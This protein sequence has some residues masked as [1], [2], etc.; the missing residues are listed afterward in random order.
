M[1]LYIQ[2]LHLIKIKN[3][4]EYK[5]FLF[6]AA[7]FLTACSSE[8][9]SAG[10]QVHSKGEYIYRRHNEHLAVHSVRLA[11][12]PVY[13]WEK[14]K[15]GKYP[16]ITKEFF[17]CKGSSLNP[18]NL[19][20]KDTELVRYYDCG[21][22]RRHSLPLRDQ[23]EFIYPVLIDLLNYLQNITGNQA[24]IT[25]GHCCPDHNL[26]L[27]PSSANQTSKHLLGAEVD[28]Y[29]R[30]FENRPHQV[31]E[32]IKNYYKDNPQYKGQR[33]F[34]EFAVYEKSDT[35]VSTPPVYNK[36]IFVKVFTKT[37]GRDFDNRHPYPYLSVQV[38]YDRDLDE[39]V[40]YSWEKAFHNL[41]RH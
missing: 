9:T 10:L 32:L 22:S 35:G 24:V 18:V 20:Q 25:C 13:P 23:Q 3:R 29:I 34:E 27:N 8:D 5:Y 7:V 30:G 19:V 33:A 40:V 12:P 39:K 41:H 31:V 26:Y 16:K 1:T 36:E 28:F 2:K 21:G 6:L 15:I 17:R 37:E 4:T 38:R 14:G 11:E